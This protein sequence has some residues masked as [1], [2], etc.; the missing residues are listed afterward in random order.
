LSDQKVS[1]GIVI[2]RKPFLLI[3]GWKNGQYSCTYGVL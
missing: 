1:D 3:M 2:I